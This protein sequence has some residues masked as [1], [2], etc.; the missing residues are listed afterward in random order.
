MDEMAAMLAMS[1]ARLSGKVALLICLLGHQLLLFCIGRWTVELDWW[2]AVLTAFAGVA[3]LSIGSVTLPPFAAPLFAMAAAFVTMRY[4]YEMDLW[5]HLVMTVAWYLLPLASL[6]AAAMLFDI[7]PPASAPP[8]LTPEQQ[9]R[10]IEQLKE[11][12]DPPPAPDP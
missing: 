6:F 3:G 9:Q 4:V 2:R 11:S 7:P 8:P 5:Q 10:L 12:G 1:E